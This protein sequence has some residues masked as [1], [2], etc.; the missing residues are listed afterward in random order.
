MLGA[1][2][3]NQRLL[4]E[5]FERSKPGPFT[6][7]RISEEPNLF[8]ERA[9]LFYTPSNRLPS[10]QLGDGSIE[11]L[12]PVAIPTIQ[13]VFDNRYGHSPRFWVDLLQRATNKVRWIPI[14]PAKVIIT[15][16]DVVSYG[17][18]N[19]CT[20]QLVDALKESTTGRKDNVKLYYFGAIFDDNTNDMPEYNVLE[21]L[22]LHPGQSC[23]RVQVY[24]VGSA[25][26]NS[27]QRTVQKARRR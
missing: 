8:A 9:A 18:W 14:R 6:K 13:E 25:L 23:T 22:I 12:L 20:K 7:K 17:E 21:E 16:Y 27:L 24:P 26:N 19:L 15:R 3:G 4:T 5:L 2:M 10:D 1:D 11:V